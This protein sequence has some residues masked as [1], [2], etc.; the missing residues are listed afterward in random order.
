VTA[1][2]TREKCEACPFAGRDE[3]CHA[4]GRGKGNLCRLV[5]R[6]L[7]GYREHVRR[8]TVEADPALAASFPPLMTRARNLAGAVGRFVSSGLPRASSELRA[9]RAA[10]CAACPE[11]VGGRCRLCGCKL[12]WK[13]A[14][15]TES[16]P[17]DPPRW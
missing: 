10:I 17:D 1:T 2:P 13:Q 6:G 12:R 5:A 3:A 15:A 16:C 9:E 7:P 14:M 11:L 4:Q 8:M